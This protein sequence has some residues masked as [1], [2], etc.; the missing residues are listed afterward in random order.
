MECF[1]RS[2]IL[3]FF[4]SF[5]G[6]QNTLNWL[7]VEIIFVPEK[8]ILA[9]NK[10]VIKFF[11]YSSEKGKY[12][13]DFKNGEGAVGQGDPEHKPDVTITMNEEVFLKIFNRKR[14][15]Q[16]FPRNDFAISFCPIL[17]FQTCCNSA[18]NL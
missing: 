10:I 4:T 11:V 18:A 13:V 17:Q 8:D 1:Y 2:L 14:N 9:V 6:K 3:R 16:F 5:Y 7:S 15:F 12:Y